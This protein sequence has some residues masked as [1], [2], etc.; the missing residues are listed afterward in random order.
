MDAGK[1]KK[2]AISRQQTAFSNKHQA[3]GIERSQIVAPFWLF[4][5]SA[6]S[7]QLSA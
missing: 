6:F 5:L 7:P 3:T 1:V 2:A 4:S